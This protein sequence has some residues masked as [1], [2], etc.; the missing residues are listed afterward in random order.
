MESKNCPEP[1]NLNQNSGFWAKF[2]LNLWDSGTFFDCM[3]TRPQAWWNSQ[4]PKIIPFPPWGPTAMFS[5]RLTT[6]PKSGN[7]YSMINGWI[8]LKPCTHEQIKCVLFAQIWLLYLLIYTKFGH[9]YLSN[10]S[11]SFIYYIQIW[12]VGKFHLDFLL[13]NTWGLAFGLG[14][15]SNPVKK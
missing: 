1:T 6:S 8:A 4:M 2:D 14:Q 12:L 13:W 15:W 10:S 9:M 3:C 7:R 5:Q 11:F